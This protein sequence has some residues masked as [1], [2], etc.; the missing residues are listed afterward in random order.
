MGRLGCLGCIPWTCFRCLSASPGGPLGDPWG[1]LGGQGGAR[2][3]LGYELLRKGGLAKSL[4]LLHECVHLGSRRLLGRPRVGQILDQEPR[5]AKEREMETIPIIDG[6]CPEGLIFRQVHSRVGAG[7]AF[8]NCPRAKKRPNIAFSQRTSG[9]NGPHG[10]LGGPLGVL[11]GPWGP[12]GWARGA[13]GDPRETLENHFSRTGGLVTSMI[14][15][16]GWINVA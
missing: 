16:D 7:C 8:T 15:Q 11:G 4:V 3:N 2:G 14:L 10:I 5:R 13:V 6:S 9:L 12:L 1:A